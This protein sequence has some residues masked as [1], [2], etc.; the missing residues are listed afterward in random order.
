MHSQNHFHPLSAHSHSANHQH[1]WHL[2]PLQPAKAQAIRE[3]C[4]S[5]TTGQRLRDDTIR[6]LWDDASLASNTSF[7]CLQSIRTLH[8][9]HL[10]FPHRNRQQRTRSV[11]AAS[12]IH[13][14]TWAIVLLLHQGHSLRYVT[15]IVSGD[16]GSKSRPNGYG[17]KL[18]LYG[19]S[20]RHEKWLELC[21]AGCLT[22]NE[23]RQWIE[24]IRRKLLKLPAE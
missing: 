9:S 3:L 8:I 20:G 16:L 13:L 22:A 2:S 23:K 12:S 5:M 10:H 6:S 7:R 4:L 19:W 11:R 21:E 24:R 14:D 15:V 1:S 17:D 18:L